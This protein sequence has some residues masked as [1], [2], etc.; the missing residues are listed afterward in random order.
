MSAGGAQLVTSSADSQQS[1]EDGLD[2]FQKTGCHRSTH[3]MH[4][5]KCED[6]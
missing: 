5:V 6:E 3:G 2:E 1:V 4:Y